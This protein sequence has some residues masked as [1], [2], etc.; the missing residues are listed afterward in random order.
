MLDMVGYRLGILVAPIAW[1]M[2]LAACGG[3]SNGA[4]AAAATPTPVVVETQAQ[5][6]GPME[7]PQDVPLNTPLEVPSEV[8][9]ELKAIWEAW[10]L[11]SAEYVDQSKLDPV[12]FTEKAIRGSLAIL[13]D[14]HTHYVSPEVLEF[15]R[16]D[17]KG[18]FEG[19][20]ATVQMRLDGK[21]IIVAP[22][23][24]GPAEAAGIKPGDLVL[25]VDGE[26]IE[27][28]SL[29]EAVGIIRGPRGTTVNLL[30]KHLGAIDPVDITVVRDVIPL[31]SVRLR[32][33]PGDRIAH[34]RLTSFNANTAETMSDMIK[35]ALASGAEA[36][37]LDVRDN[38]GGLLSS[39]VDVTSEFIEDGLVLYQVDAG[40]RRTDYKAN[41]GG[42][43]TDI[44]LVILTNEF[45]A[46]ASEILAGAL[47]DHNR[48][49]VVG[50]TTFGKGSV[51]IMRR[52]SNG[53]GLVITFARWYTPEGR[54]I[55]G[56]GLDPDI[57]VVA[58][59]RRKADTMQLERAI[60]ELE[61]MI[62]AT[63]SG[64]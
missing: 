51:N 17:L 57:E 29:L 41:R 44:P 26:S 55:E 8:P 11:L 47:Q 34:I 33:K 6:V 15:E 4:G 50:G 45:S 27:G 16:Q 30:I 13:D 12:K 35:E 39:V 21:L 48:A 49:T 31:I 56:K 7:F 38:A 23:E 18:V 10:A 5:P 2:L 19:I 36:L 54:V 32:S 24:G 61:A 28:L 37:I 1:V 43:A 62:G 14:P 60:Q 58:R 64:T 22:I 25:E 20:G 42:V 53:G 63:D 40:G 52:L 59:D 46:S 3:G 9:K